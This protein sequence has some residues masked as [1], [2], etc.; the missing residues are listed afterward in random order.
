MSVSLP[1]KYLDIKVSHRTSASPTWT[2]HRKGPP[3]VG[4]SYCYTATTSAASIWQA[5]YRWPH[6]GRLPCHRPRPDRLRPIVEADCTVQLQLAGGNTFLILQ[7]ER[8]ERAM[9]VGHSMG[10]MLA[11][12]LATQYPKA[13]ERLVIYNPIG[14]TDGRF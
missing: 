11:A 14:L 7:K 3:T 6:E 8:I 5:S 13:I 1:S 2:S 10:G 9:V 12:R 4:P